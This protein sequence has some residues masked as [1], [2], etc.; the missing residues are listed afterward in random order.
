MEWFDLMDAD[1][2]KTGRKKG[3]LEVH[4]DGDWHQSVHIWIFRENQTL[5]QKRAVDKDCFPGCWDA[6]CTGHVSAGETVTDGAMRELRE[7]L[8][9]EVASCALHYSFTQPLCV[10]DGRFI[11]NEWNDVFW[12]DFHSLRGELVYQK[13]EISD[14]QWV[15]TVFLIER[16]TAH[17]P[18]YCISLEE[19]KRVLSFYEKKAGGI[20]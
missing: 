1:G 15:E 10:R 11:S 3:R 19:L 16:L 12:L 13:E 14:L 4:R 17:D 9:V 7:E 8:G 18:G 5:L 20:A 2:R 6:A